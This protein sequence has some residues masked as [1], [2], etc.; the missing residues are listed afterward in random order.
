MNR[1]IASEERPQVVINHGLSQLH[2]VTLP[3]VEPKTAGLV[4]GL[5]ADPVLHV[6]LLLLERNDITTVVPVPE[7]LG[8]ARHDD[9]VLMPHPHAEV[10]DRGQ[11]GL[12]AGVFDLK[13][14][15][16]LG[17]EGGMVVVAIEIPPGAVVIGRGNPVLNNLELGEVAE[18]V[19][20]KRTVPV[21]ALLVGG[22][23]AMGAT[24]GEEKIDLQVYAGLNHSP[25]DQASLG[26]SEQVDLF[27]S[28]VWVSLKLL[29]RDDRLPPH[30]VEHGGDLTVADFDALDGHLIVQ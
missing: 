13:L 18:H 26:D 29:A 25:G 14:V 16:D 23:S 19:I 15:V 9:R 5:Q 6:H 11:A 17:Q 22:D 10:F 7:P 1:S 30:A 2:V 20:E 3:G 28:K 4:Q 27:A 21:I 24:E 12:I 8:L